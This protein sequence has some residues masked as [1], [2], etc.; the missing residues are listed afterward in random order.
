MALIAFYLTIK[1]DKTITI[2]PKFAWLPIL[3]FIAVGTNDSMF[4]IAEHF[5]I[6]GDFVV[7]LATAFGVAL[8]LGLI[9]LLAK[10]I[11][12]KEKFAFKNIVA[13]VILGLLNWFSTLYFLK[14][15]DIFDVSVFVPLY[16]IG[17]V[18]L[19]AII[20]F[21]VFNEKLT[22]LNWIGILLALIAIFLIAKFWFYVE[23]NF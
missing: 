13:G 1:K 19:S 4:K 11:E 23:I 22:R 12:S 9:V 7:F 15:L 5:Y 8:L 17:V 18:A 20:G 3:L 10:R 21:L 14:G 16:N 6:G 2:N